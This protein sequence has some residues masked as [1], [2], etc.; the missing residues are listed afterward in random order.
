MITAPFSNGLLF[1]F[2]PGQSGIANLLDTSRGILPIVA[3]L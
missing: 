3:F 1:H 2:A